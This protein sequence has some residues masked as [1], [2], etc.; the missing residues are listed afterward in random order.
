MPAGTM[1]RVSV[2]KKHEYKFYMSTGIEERRGGDNNGGAWMAVVLVVMQG[3]GDGVYMVS[4]ANVVA[5]GE[6][7]PVWGF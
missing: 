7:V 6:R 4:V 5:I 3:C 2:S 1:R